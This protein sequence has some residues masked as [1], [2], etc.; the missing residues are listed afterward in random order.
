MGPRNRQAKGRRTCLYC[1]E[2]LR[3]ERGPEACPSCGVVQSRQE[4]DGVW[5][6]EPKLLFWQKVLRGG[7]VVLTALVGLALFRVMDSASLPWGLGLLF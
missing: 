7:G 3:V 2:P 4:Q 1:Y 5:S 6:L